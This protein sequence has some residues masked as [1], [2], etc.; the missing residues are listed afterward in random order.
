MQSLQNHFLVAMP[1][2]KGPYFERSVIYLCDHNEEGAMGIV[3]NIPVDL[4][5]GELLEQLELPVS[6]AEHKPL[7]QAV[8]QGGPVADDR[9][10]VVHT[11]IAGFSSSLE[12]QHDIMV[13]TS[14]DILATLGTS[15]EPDHYI[16]ALGYAGWEAGQLEQEIAENTWLT[17]PADSNILFHT[18]FAERWQA[19]VNSLGIDVWQLSSDAGHA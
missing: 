3:I 8:L 6:S 9:G 13:T 1:S 11:P 7:K 19:A 5:L 14:K 2:L 12:L 16:L 10:F 18:H 15:E 4:Q 17:L